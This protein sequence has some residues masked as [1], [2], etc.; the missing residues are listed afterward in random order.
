MFDYNPPP[1]PPLD[2][3]PYSLPPIRPPLL[4]QPVSLSHISEG[5]E[6]LTF[7]DNSAELTGD[8]GK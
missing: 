3:P 5:Y 6:G 4:H 7:N 2:R 1:L 8:D